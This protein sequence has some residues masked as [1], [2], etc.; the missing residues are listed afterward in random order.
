MGKNMFIEP[1]GNVFPCYAFKKG[2][3]YLGNVISDGLEKIVKSDEFVDLSAHT[4]DTN[5]KCSKCDYRYLC[6]GACR[7]W[8]GEQT[9]FDLDIPPPECNGLYQR[10]EE[11]YLTSLNY[12]RENYLIEKNFA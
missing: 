12:L 3:S 7:A 5:S 1:N 11:I 2:H 6:G 8:G 10:A 4:V 9:Q